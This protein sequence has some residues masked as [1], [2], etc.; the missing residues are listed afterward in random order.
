MPTASSRSD[1][2][3]ETGSNGL[4]LTLTSPCMKQPRPSAPASTVIVTRPL[5]SHSNRTYQRSD[6][7]VRD[8]CANGNRTGR[9]RNVGAIA[10]SSQATPRVLALVGGQEDHGRLP[11][12]GADRDAKE[13]QRPG[14][15]RSHAL[16]DGPGDDLQA[17]QRC[18]GGTA[19]APIEKDAWK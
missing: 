2:G 17:I 16:H 10:G 5:G 13:I 3:F 7:D 19:A 15:P 14:G 11:A 8:L 9:H 4:K 18:D 1:I 6:C 12:R